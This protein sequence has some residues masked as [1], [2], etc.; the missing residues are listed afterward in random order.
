MSQ[1]RLLD[2]LKLAGAEAELIYTSRFAT[3]PSQLEERRGLN[4]GLSLDG[5]RAV[6]GI[7][8]EGW[9]WAPR[10]KVP[11]VAFCEAVLVE[12]LPFEDANSAEVLGAQAEWE[13]AAARL[14]DAVVA[15]SEFAAARVAEAYGVPRTR[16]SVLPIPFDLQAWQA[17]LPGMPK[18]PL[19]LAVGHLYPRKNYGA[20]LEAW[21]D[22]IATFPEARLIV[23]GSGP[24]Q[25]A[26]LG[27]ARAMP[28]ITLAGHMPFADL[29]ELY[30]RASVFC[31]P[32]LQENFGIAVVEGLGSG[33][34]VVMH[35]HPA[36]LEN[37]AG[38]P[39]VW[40]IDARR[41][42]S[43]AAAL[44]E[45]LE[46]PLPSEARLVGLKDKLSPLAIGRRL[47]SLVE[48]LG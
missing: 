12:V 30:A 41:P 22:V 3:S 11:Y 4:A 27:R 24:E 10:R 1:E 25:E 33:G 38:L 35:K 46:A 36:L 44:I 32:S 17:S 34:N 8:G 37:T 13:A 14:A 2:A 48:S 31:H 16:I 26:L 28:S 19:V 20:L 6:L 39:G 21:P 9:L 7:D 40:A 23:V 47:R 15:R 45:A 42:N 29:L 5:Y 43:L 18:E